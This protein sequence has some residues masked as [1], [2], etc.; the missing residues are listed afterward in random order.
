M[1]VKKERSTEEREFL[2]KLD[3]IIEK[4]KSGRGSAVHPP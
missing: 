1:W 4:I 2:K 3:G